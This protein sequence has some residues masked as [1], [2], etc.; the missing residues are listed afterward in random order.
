MNRLFPLNFARAANAGW[1]EKITSLDTGYKTSRCFAARS[2]ARI[3]EKHEN[4]L[5]QS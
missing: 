2:A 1:A 4:D 5:P 3:A